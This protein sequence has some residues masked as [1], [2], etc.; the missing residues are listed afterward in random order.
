MDSNNIILTHHDRI[1]TDEL[2]DFR[3]SDGVYDQ[4][5]LKKW[6]KNVING[7]VKLNPMHQPNKTSQDSKEEPKKE[8]L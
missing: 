2:F 5:Q 6:L 8:E 3:P 7:K 1:L 4:N